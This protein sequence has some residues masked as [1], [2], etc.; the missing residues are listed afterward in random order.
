MFY[1][2]LREYT[3]AV[4]SASAGA[5]EL[6]IGAIDLDKGAAE[7]ESAMQSLI[8]GADSLK[9][10]AHELSDGTAELDSRSTELTSKLDSEIDSVI[11][12]ALGREV[13]T[14]SF[15]SEKNTDVRA[16]QFVIKTEAVKIAETEA[17]E[18]EAE[19]ELNFWQKLLR[20]FGLY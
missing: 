15:V 18:P 20:L 5:A 12:E 6:S 10:G 14:G 13:E 8:S 1:S 11:Y 17:A 4:D 16:V 2:G 3:A 7:L 19:P 9:A